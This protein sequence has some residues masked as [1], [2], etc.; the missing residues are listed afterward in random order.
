MTGIKTKLYGAFGKLLC[1]EAIWNFEDQSVRS[2]FFRIDSQEPQ[3][4]QH[5]QELIPVIFVSFIEIDFLGKTV[6][7]KRIFCK[8]IVNNLVSQ[9]GFGNVKQLSKLCSVAGGC[10]IQTFFRRQE[11]FCRIPGSGG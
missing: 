4:V 11:L 7:K 6:Q 2:A 5:G 1:H 8:I 10:A 3:I 9:S